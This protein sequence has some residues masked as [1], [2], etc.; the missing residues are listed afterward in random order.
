MQK[1]LNVLTLVGASAGA[2]LSALASAE[3]AGPALIR[4]TGGG[5]FGGA[6]GFVVFLALGGR[7][8]IMNWYGVPPVW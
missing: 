2:A 5:A 1:R 3:R 8:D 4:A 7:V 6:A